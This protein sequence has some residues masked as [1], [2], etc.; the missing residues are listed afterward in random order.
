MCAQAVLYLRNCLVYCPTAGS[1][2]AAA[3]AR[4]LWLSFPSPEES[5]PRSSYAVSAATATRTRSTV[6]KCS[7]YATPEPSTYSAHDCDKIM[8]IQSVSVRDT[9]LTVVFFI[10]V[11]RCRTLQEFLHIPEHIFT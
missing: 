5:P 7:S 3:A 6:A 1:A 9:I 8:P 4:L 10:L 11:C 2:A